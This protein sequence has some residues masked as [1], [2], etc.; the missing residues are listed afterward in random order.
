MN[1]LKLLT[2]GKTDEEIV[3]LLILMGIVIGIMTFILW[4]I[5]PIT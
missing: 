5:Y 4:I 3:G 2:E 1:W